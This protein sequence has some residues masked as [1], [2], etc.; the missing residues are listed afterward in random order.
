M[1]SG[2][3]LAW[4]LNNPGLVRSHSHFSQGNGAIGHCGQYAIFSSPQQ[5]RMAL[6]SW[7][8]SKKYHDSTLKTVAEHYQENTPNEFLHQISSLTKISPDAKL[9]FL[10]EQEIDR[11]VIGIEKLCGY[12]SSG[13]ENFSLL[14]KIIAKIENEKTG[15]SSYLI[16]D[17]VV[18]S[19]EEALQR[20]LSHQ[21]D[22]VIVYGQDD[23]TYLRSRPKHSFR[24]I[25]IPVICLVPRALE[26][27]E[28]ETLVRI[29]GEKK[30]GQCVWGFINGIDN[31]KEEALASAAL[32]S[33][34]AKGERVLSMPNDTIWKGIDLLICGVL[35]VSINTPLAVLTAK[36]LKYLLS[37]A[38]LE[39]KST[40]VI[41]FAHSQGAIYIEHALELLSPDERNQLRI[42]TFGGG[43]FIAPGKSHP[44]SHNYAS[45]AD[46]V[47]R[48]G[49]PFT[50]CLALKRYYGLKNGLSEQ[51][52]IHQLA[53]EDAILDLD[54]IDP[55][56][57]ATYTKSREKH[58][59][60]EFSKIK[61]ITILDPDPGS[62]WKHDFT[63]E[64]YQTTIHN[65]IKRYQ[66]NE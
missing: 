57:L 5:G 45:A 11:L 2:G 42:F 38:K 43:S 29:T 13:N 4:R 19:K 48:F 61:H 17:N 36:F 24:K 50:Q 39:A 46:Y 59:E 44:D 6:S 21:L 58:Y 30:S 7:L 63:S 32:I 10:T 40:P 12:A 56:T 65:I 37:V 34:A 26:G 15:E 9:K 54:S 3:S 66:K 55:K 35:K 62:N 28:I 53:Y 16:E 27:K 60:Q 41:V 20:I 1:A 31:T 64:C 52:V 33:Q 14:P 51:Q 47:C 23:R 18:L 22:A 49:S 8:H 25:K